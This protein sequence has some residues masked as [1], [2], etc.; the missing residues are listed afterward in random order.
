MMMNSKYSIQSIILSAALLLPTACAEDVYIQRTMPGGQQP[1]TLTAS[2]EDASGSAQQMRSADGMYN[3]TT[4]FDGGEQVVAF[5]DRGGTSYGGYYDVGEPDASH[6]SELSYNSGYELAYPIDQASSSPTV[7]LYGVYPAASVSQSNGVPETTGSHTVAYNQTNT[8]EGNANYKASDLMYA[9]TPVT[10]SSIADKESP[11]NLPFAHQLVKL[12]LTV[13][14]A[15]DIYEVTKV[16]VA[17]V[18]RKVAITAIGTEGLTLGDVSSAD[19]TEGDAILLSEGET[20]S[21]AQQTNTYCCLFPIQSWGGTDF[22]TIEADDQT[23]VFQ[24]SKNDWIAGREYAL[25]LNLNAETLNATSTIVDWD[26]TKGTCL[27][28]AP[29]TGGGSFNIRTVEPM[30][31]TGSELEPTPDVYSKNEDGTDKDLL[32]KDTDYEMQWFSNTDA[33]EG[34][35]VVTGKDGTDYAGLIGV[36]SFEITQ[37]PITITAIDQEVAYGTVS[38]NFHA[39]GG[40]YVT[41]SEK[42]LPTGQTIDIA[43]TATDAEGNAVTNTT[44]VGSDYVITPSAAVIKSSDMRVITA[45]YGITYAIGTLTIVKAPATITTAPTAKDEFEEDVDNVLVNAGVPN[46]GTMMYY[47]SDTES[48]PAKTADGWSAEIPTTQDDGTYYVYYYVAGDDNH[49]DSDVS[50][51]VEVEVS[52]GWVSSD[53]TVAAGGKKVKFSQG[54]LRA[55]WNGSSWTWAFADNQWDYIG[56]ATKTSVANGNGNIRISGNGTVNTNNVTVDL[57]GWVGESSNWSGTNGSGTAAEAVMHGITNSTA[58]NNVS[59][60]GNKT[61]NQGETLKSDWGN[62]TITNGGG[63]TWRTLTSAEWTY[64]FNTR[65]TGGTVFGTT[66]ARYAHATINT[67]GTSVNGMILFPDGVNIASSEVTTAGTVNGNS[68]FETKCTTAQWGKLAAK[69]CVFLPSA[70][71]RNVTNVGNVGSSGYYWSSTAFPSSA[72]RAYY[73]RFESGY[74]NPAYDGGRANGSS[75]RLVT[76]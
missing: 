14:K 62:V 40:S 5:L 19:D 60:Y 13:I 59:G 67:D 24:L 22:I 17:N 39:S 76:P 28:L 56:D 61:G 63:Y 23:A 20:G 47:K 50:G 29:T 44:H 57:F 3:A 58:T 74:F 69:G 48:E 2:G 1:I 55:T 16:S 30:E 26:T 34:I 52:F 68:A 49:T 25:T 65:T 70:G 31:Y 71:Y 72:S 64:L 4:G 37:R 15:A 8:T 7:T 43:L 41:T 51:P 27:V 54:N 21:N 66:Q 45:N 32:T 18:K 75:V 53:F 6:K 73:M 12:E 33:G 9:T 38:T 11:V 35:I 42:P 10:W 36:R 46:G